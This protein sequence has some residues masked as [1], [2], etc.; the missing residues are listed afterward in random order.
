MNFSKIRI[1]FNIAKAS[2]ERRIDFVIKTRNPFYCTEGKKGI[3]FIRSGYRNPKTLTREKR[4]RDCGNLTIL[5]IV[6]RKWDRSSSIR[7]HIY[8]S[9]LLVTLLQFEWNISRAKTTTYTPIVN[10]HN[11]PFPRTISTCTAYFSAQ[12][13]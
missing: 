8:G 13:A 3:E 6:K 7:N 12:T 11:K 5:M 2:S 1:G 10:S 9:K 4:Y